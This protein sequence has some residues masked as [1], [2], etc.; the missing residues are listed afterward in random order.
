MEQWSR[1][2]DRFMTH[3]CNRSQSWTMVPVTNYVIWSPA[4]NI[5]E[6][7][8]TLLVMAE[9]AGVSSDEINIKY[10]ANRLLVW[11]QRRQPNLESIRVVHRMEIQMGPFA[12]IVDLPGT[13]S[14]DGAEASLAAGF[15]Q[16]RLPKHSAA[17]NGMIPI[18]SGMK[19]E[20]ERG[21]E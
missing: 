3:V 7:E 10:E 6:T 21:N 19:E 12:F 17:E 5:Y 14:A 11:G 20:N 4:V 9:V 8:D 18:R 15:L 2:V 16:I 13:V 1:D